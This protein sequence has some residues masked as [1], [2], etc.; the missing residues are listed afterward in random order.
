MLKARRNVGLVALVKLVAYCKIILAVLLLEGALRVPAIGIKRNTYLN[1]E[2][3]SI[4]ILVS[5][6]IPLTT[7]LVSWLNDCMLSRVYMF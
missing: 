5:E 1:T 2:L 4:I 7:N 3:P 6:V